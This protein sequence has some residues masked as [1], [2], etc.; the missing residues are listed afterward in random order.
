VQNNVAVLRVYFPGEGIRF[1]VRRNGA[2]K[3]KRDYGCGHE[4]KKEDELHGELS[5]G[6]GLFF[7]AEKRR[8]REAECF[9][10]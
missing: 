7:N 10:G 5:E 2:G 9:L 3:R 4:E 8:G 1:V 6:A